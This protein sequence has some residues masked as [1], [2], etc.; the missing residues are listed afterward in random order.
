MNEKR[1]EHLINT[2]WKIFESVYGTGREHSI[3]REHLI[4]MVQAQYPTVQ[5][6]E[7]RLAI[8]ELRDRGV[9]ICS[10]G[11][12]KGGYYRAAT[13]V[14]LE[15]YLEREVRSRA[16]DLLETEAILRRAADRTWGPKQMEMKFDATPAR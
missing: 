12:F 10:T 9:P 7:I 4:A 1:N 6:R 15:E 8:H 5:E 11:G 3:S 16:V 13:R 2:L 14:E